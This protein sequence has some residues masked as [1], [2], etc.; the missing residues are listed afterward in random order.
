[1]LVITGAGESTFCAGGDLQH[2]AELSEIGDYDAT[3]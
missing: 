3:A 1:V 2:A